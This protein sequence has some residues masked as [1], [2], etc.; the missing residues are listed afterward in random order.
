MSRGVVAAGHPVSAEAGAAVLR[1]GGNAVDA[2]IGAVL[3]SCACEPL[4]TG[5]GAG[6]Y[7]LV[8]PPGPAAPVLLDFFVEAPGRGADADRRADLVPVEVSFGDAVQTFH[9][10]AASV[11]AYGVPAGLEAAAARFGTVPL[12]DLA[13]PAERLARRGV[14][15]NGPQAYVVEILE[16]IVTSTPEI[17]AIYAPD[18]RLLRVGDPVRQPELADALERLGADGAEPF[19]RGEVA[20]AVA[21]W[22]EPRGGMLTRADLAAYEVA[23]RDPVRAAYRGRDVLTNPPPSAGGTLIAYALALLD[24]EPG[25]PT[26]TRLVDV[27]EAAQ[28][29]RTPAFLEGLATPGFGAAFLASRLGSTTHV[30]V[31]DADGWACAVT[32]SNGEGSGIVV[33]GTGI[34]LNNMMGEHDLNPLGFHRDPPGRRMPSMMAPT[35]VMRDGAPGARARERGLQPHPLGDHPGDLLGGGPRARGGPGGRGAAPAPRGRRRLR[36]AGDRSRRA[37]GVRAG[38]RAV[39]GAQPVLRRGAGGGARHADRRALRRRRPA[40]GRGGGGGVRRPGPGAGIALAAALAGC[41]NAGISS[42][43]L[44][45]VTRG[46]TI[47]GARLGLVVS[48]GGTVRCNGGPARMLASAD[49]LDARALQRDLAPAARRGLRL[50]PGPRSLLRY[51]VRSGNGTVAWSDTSRGQPAVLFRLAAFTRRVAKGVCGLAR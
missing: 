21:A 4:L 6:G 14:P 8:V 17:A 26:S 45:A 27:M 42:P 50:A 43:D 25:P 22:L 51:R 7:M 44:F 20:E 32:C 35:V 11:G 46:G 48:D 39:P 29:E 3:A 9:V 37:R 15:L 18:G 41:G 13:A 1:E 36:R 40:P 47:P 38:G 24:R 19:Y 31:L 28:A 10:G 12:A 16:G 49:L 5:L 34:H 2:A 30:S 23:A 33:P